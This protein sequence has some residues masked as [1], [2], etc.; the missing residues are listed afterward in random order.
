MR[1]YS[2][3]LICLYGT[4]VENKVNIFALLNLTG[5]TVKKHFD[6]LRACEVPQKPETN[7]NLVQYHT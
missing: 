7:G 3:K 2:V 4:K 1:N 5:Y 6:R